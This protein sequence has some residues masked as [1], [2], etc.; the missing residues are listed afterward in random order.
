MYSVVSNHSITSLPNNMA[1][2]NNPRQLDNK[3]PAALYDTPTHDE[4]RDDMLDAS[5][6]LKSKFAHLSKWETLKTFKRLY[7]TGLGV[8][9][10]G[11]YAGYCLS[12]SGNI[13]ANPGMST[14]NRS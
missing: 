13:I 14:T 5:P 2:Y 4:K 12:V 1:T 8:S 3:D 9:L 11:M 6:V 7:A 10:G